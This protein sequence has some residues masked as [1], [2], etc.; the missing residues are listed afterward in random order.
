MKVYIVMERAHN[1]GELFED[2]NHYDKI[3]GVGINKETAKKIIERRRAEII[4]LGGIYY[5]ESN[6]LVMGTVPKGFISKYPVRDVRFLYEI[7][8]KER[9]P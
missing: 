8:E 4:S 2:Y 3:I 9:Q 1:D 5:P 6:E 7:I